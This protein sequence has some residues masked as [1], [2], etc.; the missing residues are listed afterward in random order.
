MNP[1][2]FAE[3]L[4]SLRVA[5]RCE[6]PELRITVA[7]EMDLACEDLSPAV[8]G[9]ALDRIERA[10]IDL[11]G[12]E[13]LDSVGVERLIALR[14]FMSEQGVAVALHDPPAL[15]RRVIWAAGA[16]QELT[17]AD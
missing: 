9:I 7:G 4:S 3:S 16:E 5:V 1:H 11:S 13:F 12:L 2:P 10:V 8:A 15:V 17:S 6:P 14:Q